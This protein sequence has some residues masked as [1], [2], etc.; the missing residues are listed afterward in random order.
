MDSEIAHLEIKLKYVPYPS[1]VYQFQ[2]TSN[3]N[4]QKWIHYSRQQWVWW[5]SF[6]VS[7]NNKK[8]KKKPGQ[9][10]KS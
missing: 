4:F 1:V 9:T 2:S 8:A 7:G 5:I 6:P 10:H 3:L